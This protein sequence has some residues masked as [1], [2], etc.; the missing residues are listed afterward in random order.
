[1]E[2]EDL[3][4]LVILRS[5]ANGVD[6][7]N[8]QF[9]DPENPI[10]RPQTVHAL[11]RTERQDRRRSLAPSRAMAPWTTNED[12]QLLEGF[13]AGMSPRDLG[14]KHRRSPKA[15]KARLAKLGRYGRVP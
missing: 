7:E 14:A 5:L 4:A 8:G 15:V 1:M 2:M 3:Q 12:R 11:E 9:L 13:D 6:P 10:Q